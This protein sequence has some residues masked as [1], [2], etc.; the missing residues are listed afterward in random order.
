M[1]MFIAG[2]ATGM[3]VLMGLLLLLAMAKEDDHE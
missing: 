1:I 2:Y 3:I